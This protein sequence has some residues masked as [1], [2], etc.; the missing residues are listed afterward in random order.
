MSFSTEKYDCIVVGGGHAGC[1]AVLSV[2]RMGLN[3]LL[4]TIK[5]DKIG[6]M[7]CNPSVGGLA[8]SHLVFEI[9]A[10]GGEMGFIT[11][12]TGTQFRMLNTSKGAAVWSLRAQVDRILYRE[13][14]GKVIENEKNI[15]LK[16]GI[17]EKILS[18]NGKVVGVTTKEGMEYRAKTVILATGTFLNG[19]I[20]IGL[21]HYPAGR[22]DEPPAVGLSHSLEQIGFSLGRLKTGTSARI[23]R[24]SIDFSTLV[25]QFG[26]D[27]PEHF[28]MRTENFHPEQIPCYLTTTNDKMHKIILKNLDRSPLFTGAIKGVGPKYC[29]SIEDKVVRFPERKSHQV[30]L[31]PDGKTTDIFYIN[32]L[33]SSLPSDV[34]NEMLRTIKGLENVD[35]IKP[36]YGIEYDFVYPMQIFPTLETKKVNG[37]FL[38]GQINGTSGYEEAAAQGIMAGI[39]AVLKIRGEEPFILQRDKAY[40]GVLIDDLITKQI[41]EPYRMFTS[42]AEYRLLLRQDNADSRLLKYGHNF[43]LVKKKYLNRL[44]KR[45]KEVNRSIEKLKKTNVLPKQINKILKKKKSSEI[46]ETRPLFQ[47]LKRPEISIIDIQPLTG[48]IDPDIAKRIEIF[49][50]YDGY[51]EK[52]EQEVKRMKQLENTPLPLDFDYT[53]L[54]GLSKEAA[55][56]LNAVKPITLGQASRI[57]GVR[58]SDISLLMVH[59][60]RMKSDIRY[61]KTENRKSN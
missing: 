12:K 15:T 20:H 17:V 36:G 8:K 33:S 52:Q 42:L 24:K 54:K 39:N 59:L 49:A 1:E 40:I 28:C 50:K 53:T 13:E 37:L 3:T 25:P 26:D 57:S 19:L 58:T 2:A 11:D 27:Y 21:E 41:K 61:Q 60:K 31:E 23:S 55:E 4:V 45:D 30:F 56:K 14:I 44:E 22:V 38:A 32:G 6:Q 29:P 34:Q 7:S 47:I 35:I 9:D 48:T 51:I 43:G 16:E 5:I 10:L 18:Y 46:S